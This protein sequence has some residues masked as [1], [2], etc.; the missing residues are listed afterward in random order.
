MSVLK[1]FGQNLRALATE[2]G[3]LAQ[4]S[5]DLGLS[6]IQF[7]RFLR[8]ESFPKPHILEQICAYFNV[9]ARIVTEALTPAL[10]S[11]MRNETAAPTAGQS[12]MV[13]A[14]RFAC[15]SQDYFARGYDDLPDGFYSILRPSMAVMD[16]FVRFPV[17][18]KTHKGARVVRGFDAP[19]I[20]TQQVKLLRREFRGVLHH[21]SDGFSIVFYH[22][23]PAQNVSHLFISPLSMMNSV[24]GFFGFATVGRA[25]V[26][27]RRRMCRVFME[28]LPNG[29]REALALRRQ[30]TFVGEGEVALPIRQMLN[31][32]L[33]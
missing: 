21:H 29:F 18:I 6:K 32:P 30:P 20:Y 10:L 19:E 17:F 25:E 27:G 33:N 12:S 14:I 11:R 16:K 15:A 26:P 24:S 5:G 8:G 2:R 1:V 4:A 22:Q 23:P 31:L 9:D 28:H 7:Q 3:T 13:E